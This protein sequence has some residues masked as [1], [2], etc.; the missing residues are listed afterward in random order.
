[1]DDILQ[2]FNQIDWF[3]IMSFIGIILCLILVIL[4]VILFFKGEKIRKLETTVKNLDR[5]FHNLDEQAKLIVKT[6]LELNRAQEQLDRRLNALEALQKISRL[7]STTLDENEIFR[8][9]NQPILQE[10]GFEKSLILGYDKNGKLYGRVE[11]GFSEQDIRLILTQMEQEVSLCDALKEGHSFSS[12]S[13]PAQRKEQIIKIFDLRHFILC[14]ILTQ[15]GIIGLVFVGNRTDALAM[16]EGEKEIVSILANQ[17]GQAIENARLFEQ[18]YLSSQM[19]ESKV[20]DR[21][22]RLESALEEVQKISKTK[23]EFISSVSHELR[24]PL[25]SIK[26]YAS[27][28]MTGKVGQIPE[29]VRD[30]L[31]KINRHSDNLVKLINDLLDIARI[32]SGRVEM[33]L[34]PHDLESIVNNVHDLLTPQMKEK[35]LQWEAHID[36]QTPMIKI[37]VAQIDRAFINLVSNAIKFTPENGTISIRIRPEEDQVLCEVAD[38]GIGISGEDLPK[39]F[40]EFFRSE[41]AIKQNIKGTGLGLTLVKNIIEAH[42]GKIWVTS[43]FHAGTTFHFTLPVNPQIAGQ[44]DQ[45]DAKREDLN[46]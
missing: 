13:T 46:S 8:R 27:I 29:G 18:V 43:Q 17:I 39:L 14:P 6:D 33:K 31:D 44:K 23:S 7:I 21:T 41:N 2:Y 36:P 15:N 37:D 45:K 26:G 34:V 4:S 20:Q 12:D 16:T 22:K 38:T 19:L 42:Q 32:E 40:Q 30:R 3:M 10:F 35:K 9:L 24:T 25:T 28:L 11:S 5:S 1:M